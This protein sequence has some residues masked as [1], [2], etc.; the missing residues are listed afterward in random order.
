VLYL[1]HKLQK[2]FL[3]RDQAPKEEE[4]ADMHD[5][6]KQLTEMG[7]LE[8]TMIRNTKINK[9]LKAILK[10]ESIPK[11]DKFDFTGRSTALL[12]EWNKTLGVV[13]ADAAMPTPTTAEPPKPAVNGNA[14]TE[15]P[16]T[17]AEPEKEAVKPE[18]TAKPE[19][20]PTTEDKAD[21]TMKDAPAET[22][23]PAAPAAPEPAAV[24]AS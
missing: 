11:N 10:L 13:P 18:T 12:A 5:Y 9:V 7:E 2:G 6:F 4:M 17:P 20:K 8:A 19:V 23:E 15:E 24:E 14:H 21:V 3:S 22:T 1:R 16:P